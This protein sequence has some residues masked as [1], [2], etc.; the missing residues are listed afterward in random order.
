MLFEIIPLIL[1]SECLSAGPGEFVY[2]DSTFRS[3][4]YIVTGI[5]ISGNKVTKDKIVLRELTFQLHDTIRRRD[6]QFHSERS[7]EN[8]LKTSLFNYVY[9]DTITEDDNLLKVFIQIEERWYTWPEIHFNHAERNFSAWWQ[10]RDF[11]RINYGLGLS[12]YNFRGRK[13]KISVRVISGFTTQFAMVY[14]NIILD[15][16]QRHI[17]N[18]SGFCENQNRLAYITRE[19][20]PGML[21]DDHIIY[22]KQNLIV[23]YTYRQR[24]YNIHRFIVSYAK[25]QIADTITHLN[26]EYLGSGKTQS[27]FLNFIY[28]F[29]SDHTD[30]K[31]YPLA[32]SIFNFQISYSGMLNSGFDKTEIRAGYYKFC[33]LASRIYGNAGLKFQL[34]N[35]SRRPYIMTRGLGYDDFLRGYENYVMDGHNFLLFKSSVKY[36][37]LPYKIIRLGFLPLTQFNKIHISSY[38]SLFF[39]AGYVHDYYTD[40]KFYSNNLVDKPLYS[41]GIG[42]D[43]VT[44]YDKM[45]RIDFASNNI[46][47]SGVFI[48]LEQ[49]F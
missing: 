42:I 10:S 26:P 32:G 3:E 22:R 13:E 48:S 31:Y 8:L 41:G 24:L 1:L 12:Q 33:R 36:E 35:R 27:D 7:I 40:Y 44:Y 25:Y 4:F 49:K 23:K 46:G 47:D 20:V 34:G 30:L 18:I 11:T 39:N 29:E 6:L 38:L 28:Y 43:L 16:K 19:N 45:L 5:N 17:L 9:F 2:P 14:D 37:I 15:Q 21:N